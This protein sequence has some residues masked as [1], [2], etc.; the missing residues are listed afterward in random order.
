MF[1]NWFLWPLCFGSQFVLVT[2]R[3]IIYNFFFKYVSIWLHV[4]C[5]EW[6]GWAHK[7]IIH[8]SLVAVVTTTDSPNSVCNRYITEHFGGVFVFSLLFAFLKLSVL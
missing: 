6:E 5:G 4:W 1:V 7:P 8:T 2:I 3:R